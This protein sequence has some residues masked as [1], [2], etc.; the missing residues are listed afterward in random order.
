MIEELRNI[1]SSKQE[2]RKFGFTVGIVLIVLGGLFWWRGKEFYVYILAAGGL[3]LFFGWVWPVVLKPIQKV[4]MTLAIVLGWFMTR[5][6]LSVLF[7]LVFVPIGRIARLF[8]KDFL[9][10]TLDSSAESYWI[11]KDMQQEKSKE[12]YERQF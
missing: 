5:V 1:K 6:I 9:N 11:V 4:W 7:Y 12:A 2:L 3:L 10:L 8:G